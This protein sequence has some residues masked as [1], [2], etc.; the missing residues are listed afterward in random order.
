MNFATVPELLAELRAG[1]PVVVVDDAARENEGDVVLPAEQASPAW[2]NFMA[3]EARGL[4]CVSLSPERARA[5]ALGP[6]VARNTDTHGTAFTVSVDHAETGTGVSAFDRSRTIRALGADDPA[7]AFRRPGHVFP[8]VARPGGVLARPGHTE[9]ALDLARLAG[10]GGAAA[11]CEIMND[12]GTMA[13]AADL[14]RFGERHGL[15]LG[16]IAELVAYR[17][18]HDPTL[19]RVAE[20]QLPTSYGTFRVIGFKDQL[21]GAEHVAL[22]MGDVASEAPLVRVH[23][24]CLTGDVFGSSRCDCGP[25]RDAALQAISVEGRGIFV[26]LRQEGR[27]IGLMNKLRAY[28]LQDEGLDTVEANERLGFPAD[29]RDFAVAGRILRELGVSR[30]RLLTNNPEKLKS[31]RASGIEITKRVPLEVGRNPHNTSYLEVKK[32]RLGHLLEQV[33][34]VQLK[35]RE[36]S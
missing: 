19:E 17:A 20:A 27:G 33:P 24:E 28:T 35:R 16:C 32:R 8:L 26:Y 23:S 15:K 6:M 14:R 2:V 30:A 7:A 11:I 3:R 29:A 13:R 10:F 22:V 21:T 18:K 5:L 12:D 4:I 31:L 34:L 36:G 25:Q 9:A 1:R